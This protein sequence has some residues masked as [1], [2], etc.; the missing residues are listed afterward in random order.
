[1]ISAKAHGATATT[2]ATTTAWSPSDTLLSG[3]VVASRSPATAS[4]PSVAICTVFTSRR[5]EQCPGLAVRACT[6]RGR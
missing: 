2:T 5:L 6:A 3:V 1:M 4:A